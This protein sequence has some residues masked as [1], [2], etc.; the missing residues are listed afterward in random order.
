M[1]HRDGWWPHRLTRHLT[2]SDPRQGRYLEIQAGGL[3]TQSRL[4][5]PPADCMHMDGAP[6]DAAPG[7][8]GRY[9]EIQEFLT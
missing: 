8:A 5:A 7:P 1:V 4:V 6:P 9:L 2:S 3:M